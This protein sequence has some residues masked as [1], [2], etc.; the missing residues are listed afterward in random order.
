[1]IL[2]SGLAAIL[3]GTVWGRLADRSSR[4]ILIGA[5]A[6]ATVVLA[7]VAG[8]LALTGGLGGVAGTAAAVFL[9]QIAYAGVRIGRKIHLTD[10]SGDD[11]R[12]SRTALSNTAI[13][14]V[15]LLGTGLGALADLVGLAALLGGLAASC[16]L[17]ATL[18]LGLDEVQDADG[19]G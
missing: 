3:S 11:N 16:A 19:T 5:G 15:L 12:A 4:G 8:A 2:A 9:L 7:T 6:L 13:G 18:A 10:M 17:G 14:G 1:M